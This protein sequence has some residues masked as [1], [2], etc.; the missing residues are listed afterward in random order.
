MLLAVFYSDIFPTARSTIMLTCHDTMNHYRACAGV[1]EWMCV[2][3][4]ITK[5]ELRVKFMGNPQKWCSDTSA[6]LL[7][8]T[9]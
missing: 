5:L 9:A 8:M 7:S 2:Q 4:A 1:A 6:Q 3:N